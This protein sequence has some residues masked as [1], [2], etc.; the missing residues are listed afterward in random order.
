MKLFDKAIFEAFENLYV[1][2]FRKEGFKSFLRIKK[3]PFGEQ[4][5]IKRVSN[6]L[7]TSKIRPINF[8]NGGAY[9]IGFLNP[10]FA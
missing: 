7:P 1:K 4:L 9:T 5:I 2:F 3:Y 6:Y 8:E 10:F